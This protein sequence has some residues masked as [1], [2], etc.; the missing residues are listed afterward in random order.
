MTL[1]EIITEENSERE[2]M[3]KELAK[4]SQKIIDLIEK[5]KNGFRKA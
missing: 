5:E 4:W 3:I 2:N 1:D